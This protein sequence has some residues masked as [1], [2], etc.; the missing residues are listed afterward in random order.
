L[1]IEGRLIGSEKA[2]CRAQTCGNTEKQ[3]NRKT[4]KQKNRKTEKQKNRTTEKQNN[5][6][7]DLYWYIQSLSQW[8]NISETSMAI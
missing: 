5:R 4:E 1:A 6:T 2:T 8:S 7:T 3:K